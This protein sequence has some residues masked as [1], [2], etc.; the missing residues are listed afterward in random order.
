[1]IERLHAQPWRHGFFSLMRRVGADPDIDP[2]GT[3]RRPN[4]E[5]FRLG[6]K[7]SLTFAPSE[8]AGVGQAGAR[9]RLRLY[10]LGMLG[11]NGPLPIHVTEIAREREENRGD[12]TLVDF[13][14][15][16][17]HRYLTQLYRTWASAQSAAAGLDRAGSEGERFSFYVGCLSGQDAVEIDKRTLPAHARLAASTHLAREA[18]DP[19]SLRMT[20]ARYFGVPVSID[21]YVFHWISLADEDRSRLG[22]PGATCTMG[23]GAIL[24]DQVPDCQ[25]RFRIVIGPVGIG[26]YLRFTPQGA[27]LSAL[28]DWVRSFVD[29]EFD[30]ELELRI[31]PDN[32]PPAVIGGPQQLGWSGWLGTSPGGKPI[33]GM[34]FDP[35][36]YMKDRRWADETPFADTGKQR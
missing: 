7:P 26:E 8:V 20:I 11:P 31:H 3:A 36:A 16:F 29:R 23:E 1:M 2:I 17:H 5:P 13:L 33:T 25:Y 14:D 28:V 30:W 21:E 22:M 19:D 35:E 6:Q 27:D 18:R 34:R 15:V 4:A 24:G 12:S 10:G 32:A 9:L